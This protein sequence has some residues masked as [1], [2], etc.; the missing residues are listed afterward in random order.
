MATIYALTDLNNFY[1]SCERVFQPKFNNKIVCVMSNNDGCVVARSN[2]AKLAGIKMGMPNFE[3]EKLMK[4]NRLEVIRFSSNYALYAEM[5]RRFHNI[6]K[7]YV[8]PALCEEYSIDENFVNLTSYAETYNL[9]EF[10]TNVKKTIYQWLGLPCCVG[11]GRSKTEAKLGN[12]IAKTNPVFKGIC[13]M[14][15]LERQGVKNAFLH[16]I[17]VSEVWGV[18]RQYAKRLNALGIYSAYDL[19]KA[20]P[21]KI[22]KLF[23]VVLQ[24]TVLELNGIAC[25]D[26]ESEP[27]PRQ[28]IVSSKSFGERVTDKNDLKEAITRFTLDA[29]RRLRRDNLVCGY[30]AAFASSSQFDKT[31]PYFSKN[32]SVPFSEPTDNPIL[33]IKAATRAIEHIYAEFVEFKRAGV[34][35]GG[36]EPKSGHRMDLFADT[37]ANEKSENLV[38]TLDEI[39]ERYGKKILG[40]GGCLFNDRPWSM[41]QAN[42]SPNYFNINECLLIN[43]FQTKK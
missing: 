30:L 15:D 17:N 21:E 36:L 26:V 4:E 42:K 39:Q 2:E 43:D 6:I 29:Q 8:D 16:T 1:V 19:M 18:G 27:Q 23:G 5:S 32:A 22:K 14:I 10:M 31:K 34:V 7:Y 35:L 12:Y 33:L 38:K 28:Q 9:V 24:R 40:F 20:E 13:S 37:A 11:L 25:Y 3:L 41:R